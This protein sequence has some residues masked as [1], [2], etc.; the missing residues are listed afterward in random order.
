MPFIAAVML[1]LRGQFTLFLFND[2]LFLFQFI[3]P[4]V[5]LVWAASLFQ[6]IFM[7]T[8]LLFWLIEFGACR[9]GNLP[10]VPIT[11]NADVDLGI[12]ATS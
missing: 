5:F 10:G 7:S 2:P 1:C 3:K 4:H 9:R 8:L 12:A 6:I 11:A